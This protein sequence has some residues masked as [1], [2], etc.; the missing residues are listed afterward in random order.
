ML[1]SNSLL[2]ND[3]SW[4]FVVKVF[5]QLH[6]IPAVRTLQELVRQ[7][8]ERQQK[9]EW[10]YSYYRRKWSNTPYCHRIK[11]DFS[12]ALTCSCLVLHLDLRHMIVKIVLHVR[13][14]VRVLVLGI[15]EV[16]TTLNQIVASILLHPM[17]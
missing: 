7:D 10:L 3:T 17:R 16:T 11:P 5:I 6:N 13:K 2:I 15:D 9:Q 1:I 8:D 14:S 12:Q 4:N